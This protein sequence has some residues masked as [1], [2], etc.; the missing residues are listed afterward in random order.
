MITMQV[1]VELNDDRQVVLTLPPEVPTG[2]TEGWVAC[3]G[4]PGAVCKV[5]ARLTLAATPGDG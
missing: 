4:A 5:N 1:T 2:T 3:A